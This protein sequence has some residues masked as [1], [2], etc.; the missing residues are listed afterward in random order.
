MK[1]RAHMNAPEKP[2]AAELGLA[3]AAGRKAGVGNPAGAITELTPSKW[4]PLHETSLHDITAGHHIY[5]LVEIRKE[6][7]A[8]RAAMGA[9][10]G[11]YECGQPGHWSHSCPSKV[12]FSG[13]PGRR[14]EG[15]VGARPGRG[16]AQEEE[17]EST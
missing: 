1:K 13:G 8:K 7:L 6:R 17:L 14:G 5:H 16:A 2:L 9:I 4:C 3:A 10:H 12:P 11:C 15:L